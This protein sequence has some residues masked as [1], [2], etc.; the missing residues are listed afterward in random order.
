M[1][2]PEP[3]ARPRTQRPV[4][5]SACV[6]IW[7]FPIVYWGEHDEEPHEVPRA[8]GQA[9]DTTLWHP[10]REEAMGKPRLLLLAGLPLGRRR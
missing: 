10:P 7:C 5:V 8:G 2:C 1:N 6:K 9:Q 4:D 3:E